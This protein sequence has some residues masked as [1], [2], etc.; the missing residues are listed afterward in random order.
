MYQ[1]ILT[2]DWW[3]SLEPLRG[4]STVSSIKWAQYIEG[5]HSETL[6]DE[7]S[8]RGDIS[9]RGFTFYWWAMNNGARCKEVAR[10][11]SSKLHQSAV[12]V[13]PVDECIMRMR[14]KYTLDFMSLAALYAFTEMCERNKE[15]L[16][17]KLNFILDQCPPPGHN[18]C[19]RRLQC[20]HWYWKSWLLGTKTNNSFFLLIFPKFRWLKNA[21][22][23][24]I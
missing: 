23:C 15:T 9:S 14:L 8:W 6:R 1:N 21:D 10:G 13:I 12:E 5:E 17:V 22:V 11:I 16:Y 4:P 20:S 3:R 7:R 18:H 19:L 24:H 2:L